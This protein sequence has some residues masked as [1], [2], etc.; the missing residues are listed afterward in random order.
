MSAVTIGPLVWYN[1]TLEGLLRLWQGFLGFIPA[2]VGAF[3]IL[4]VGWIISVGVGK[5]VADVLKRLRFN[6]I[7]ER[8][9]W[10]DALERAELQTDP[11]GFIGGIFKWV[12]MIVFLLAAVDVL[13]LEGFGAWLTND[14]L[15]YLPNVLAAALI[16]VV[17]AIIADIAEKVVRA[18]VEGMQAGYG[19]LAGGVVKWFIWT[20]AIFSALLQLNIAV[21]PI[22]VLIETFVQ[23]MGYGA[24][25]AFAIAFGLGGKDVAAEVLQG[26][27][28]RFRG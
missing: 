9:T 8:G 3:L 2:L 18:A 21:L 11:A 4:L 14:V 6:Q 26:L 5:L 28:R 16:I 19:S 17:A 1:V 22:R 15:G 27:K 25:L 13:G 23:A 24:A 7:F 20:F 10:K 12:L